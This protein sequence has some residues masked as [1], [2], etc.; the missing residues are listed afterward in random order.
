MGKLHYLFSVT[1]LVADGAETSHPGTLTPRRH[2]L[3]GII[4]LT[5]TPPPLD[6][7]E[8]PG[9]GDTDTCVLHSPQLG[10]LSWDGLWSQSQLLSNT[11][12]FT[13][14]CSLAAV[15]QAA[16]LQPGCLPMT[17]SVQEGFLV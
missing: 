15:C 17:R 9:A 13:Q 2:V 1:Q 6:Y 16:V 8:K 3:E 10:E 5:H 7:T 12:P 11:L 4:P 14:Q